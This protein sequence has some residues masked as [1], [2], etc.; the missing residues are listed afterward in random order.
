MWQLLVGT[1][2]VDYADVA[3]PEM[4][5]QRGYQV[6]NGLTPRAGRL[7]VTFDGEHDLAGQSIRVQWLPPGGTP[8][9]LWTGVIVASDPVLD[10]SLRAY[11]TQVEAQGIISDL[12]KAEARGTAYYLDRPVSEL[13]EQGV[14]SVL[15]SA[16]YDIEADPETLAIWFGQSGAGRWKAITELARTAG[17]SRRLYEAREGPVTYRMGAAVPPIGGWPLLH[18]VGGAPPNWST[19]GRSRVGES[20]VINDIEIAY[21]RAASIGVVLIGHVWGTQELD[22][23]RHGAVVQNAELATLTPLPGDSVL[24]IASASVSTGTITGV[25]NLP[26]GFTAVSE[27]TRLTGARYAGRRD[28]PFGGLVRYTVN[29]SGASGRTAEMITVVTRSGETPVYRRPVPATQT[30]G[31]LIISVIHGQLLVTPLTPPP[32]F[33][34]FTGAP[35]VQFAAW[36]VAPSAAQVSGVW[37]DGNG[38]AR[39]EGYRIEIQPVLAPVWQGGGPISLAPGATLDVVAQ[40]SSPFTDPITPVAG[41]DYTVDTG[42]IVS[43]TI[44][45]RSFADRAT[46]QFTAGSGGATISGLRLRA[47]AILDGSPETARASDQASIAQHRSRGLPYSVW[48]VLTDARAQALAAAIVADGKDPKRLVPVVVDAERNTPTFD[49]ATLTE[50][51]EHLRL[52]MPDGI[53]RAGEVVDAQYTWRRGLLRATFLLYDVDVVAGEPGPPIWRRAR[54]TAPAEITA[55]WDPPMSFGGAPVTSYDLRWRLTG[56]VT[57]GTSVSVTGTSRVVTGLTAM[58]AY[59][60]AVRARNLHGPG[61]W[62]ELL[63]AG[64]HVAR[65]LTLDMLPL[66]LDGAEI[67]LR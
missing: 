41:T 54:R 44:L 39:T 50:I 55:E 20:R 47:V 23:N 36:R 49:I 8:R 46:I 45:P 35:G 30:P 58:V 11:G 18:P 25:R 31:T 4:Q 27:A 63:G 1:S 37:T 59:D 21:T 16:L 34:E 9:I 65:R 2:P 42:S 48:G 7:R 26:T 29:T 5:A 6:A 40:S 14:A 33:T 28:W 32:G 64:G 52:V 13:I 60:F 12:V 57:W 19:L 61:P 24:A 17:P 15:D 62:A 22:I 38:N 56:T 10:P 43:V 51:G 66:N 3:R 53:I 67:F